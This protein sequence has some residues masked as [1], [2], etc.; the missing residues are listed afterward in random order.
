G[1]QTSSTRT[2]ELFWNI[3]RRWRQ[4]P[5]G[6]G[7]ASGRDGGSLLP[8]SLNAA[9]RHLRHG[10]AGDLGQHP[11]LVNQIVRGKKGSRR[12]HADRGSLLAAIEAARF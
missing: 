12:V 11:V 8:A 9:A 1:H 6:G 2:G 7:N 10:S 4:I 5:A 3:R